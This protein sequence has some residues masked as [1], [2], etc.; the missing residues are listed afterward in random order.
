MYLITGKCFSVQKKKSATWKNC[1]NSDTDMLLFL[2]LEISAK[3]YAERQLLNKE[4][5][6]RSQLLKSPRVK[7]LERVSDG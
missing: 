7:E 6:S 1:E 2:H 5:A 4:T 3:L